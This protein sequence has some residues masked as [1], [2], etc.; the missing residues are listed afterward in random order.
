M[1]K[2]TTTPRLQQK[3]R[4]DSGGETIGGGDGLSFRQKPEQKIAAVRRTPHES[5]LS[6]LF[7]ILKNQAM[8]PGHLDLPI[9]HIVLSRN[10]NKRCGLLGKFFAQ[11]VRVG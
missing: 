2:A 11:G 1:A 8:A 10:E 4:L 9:V 3:N 7:R 5:Q 6:T